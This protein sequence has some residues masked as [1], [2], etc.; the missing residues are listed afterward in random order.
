MHEL[1]VT[2]SILSIALDAAQ[3]EG[4]SRVTQIYLVLG[5]LSSI[6][7][8]SV[9]FYWDAISQGTICEGATLH[10]E[11]VPARLACLDCGSTYQLDGDLEPCP[12]CH[13]SHVKVIAGE[14]FRMDSIE[15][16]K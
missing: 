3:K 2:E 15:V 16:E 12:K 6:V 9:Q 13:G 4:A 7:D 5:R 1:S 11:R 10:F 8:D 14:E